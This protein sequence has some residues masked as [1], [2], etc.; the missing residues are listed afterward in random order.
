MCFI[1]M[2]YLY[3]INNTMKWIHFPPLIERCNIFTFYVPWK[4]EQINTPRE[5]SGWNPK[6]NQE[7][8]NYITL[9]MSFVDRPG[10]REHKRERL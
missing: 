3:Y 9:Y 7:F 4:P 10:P 1:Q 2:Q 8:S 5:K 6:T